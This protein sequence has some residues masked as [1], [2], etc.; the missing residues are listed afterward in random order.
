MHS[1]ASHHAHTIL[2]ACTHGVHGHQQHGRQNVSKH[3]HNTHTLQFLDMHWHR[4]CSLAALLL[5]IN[6]VH[7]EA[8][9]AP[10]QCPWASCSELNKFTKNVA[11]GFDGLC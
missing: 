11:R 8:H 5:C 2:K 3:L 7:F 4:V 9:E 1:P 10:T 6:D